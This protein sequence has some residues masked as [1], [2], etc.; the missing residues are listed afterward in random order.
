MQD[1]IHFID[2]QLPVAQLETH[3]KRTLHGFQMWTGKWWF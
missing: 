3:K 1:E 2:G